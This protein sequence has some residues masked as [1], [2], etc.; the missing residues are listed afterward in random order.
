MRL[1]AIKQ[2]DAFQFK[3]I[4]SG[5]EGS[6][7]EETGIPMFGTQPPLSKR[8]IGNILQSSITTVEFQRMQ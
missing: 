7:A 5:V 1:S 6:A 4:D 2:N 8:G 3:T